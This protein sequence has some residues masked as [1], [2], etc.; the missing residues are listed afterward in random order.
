MTDWSHVGPAFDRALALS[1]EERADY[2]RELARIDQ[3]LHREVVS[4]L[5]AG[6]GPGPLDEQLSIP[7]TVSGRPPAIAGKGG[8][9]DE[10]RRLGAYELEVEIGSGGMGRVF[11]ARRADGAYEQ[12]VALKVLRWEL[13]DGSVVARFLRE[14][15]ILAR[16][17]HPAITRL[18][19]GGLADGGLPYLVMEWVEGRQLD[20]HCREA[21]L[22]LEERLVLFLDVCDAVSHAH[23]AAIIHRDLKPGNILVTSEGQVKLLDFGISK[24]AD[25]AEENLTRTGSSPLTPTW[26][27]P[28]QLNGEP[29]TTAS[30]IYSLG[31]IL[32]AL[33]VGHAPHG[34]DSPSAMEL[35][36]RREKGPPQAPSTLI[37]TSDFRARALDAVVLQALAHDPSRRYST[38]EDLARDVRNLI[39]RRPVA[40]RRTGPL[41]RFLL[42]ARRNP[43]VATVAAGALVLLAATALWVNAER[44][45]SLRQA[46]RAQR[47]GQQV[48]TL[49]NRHEVLIRDPRHEVSDELDELM[50]RLTE[51]ERE[52][53]R[54]RSTLALSLSTLA[55]GWSA[56]GEW[57][58]SRQLL[59]EARTLARD[60][61]N[62][63]DHARL[64][65][66]LGRAYAELYQQ[67]RLD[68]RGLRGRA[69]E[70]Q[71]AVARTRWAEPGLAAFARA[72]DLGRGDQ[73]TALLA[74]AAR[75]A[76][77]ERFDQAEQ[78]VYE[79]IDTHPRAVEP[80]RVL[81]ELRKDRAWR[82]HLAG[83]R[84]QA[85]VAQDQ[86]RDAFTRAI[87]VARSDPRL[88]QSLCVLETN[89][90]EVRGFN[91]AQGEEIAL[92]A[93]CS[94]AAEID[95]RSA[96]IWTAHAS[97]AMRQGIRRAQL[98]GD[99]ETALDEC[100]QF[101]R[102]ARELGSMSVMPEF[103]EATCLSV[104]SDH[105]VFDPEVTRDESLRLYERILAKEPNHLQ[106]L[107]SFAIT[108]M[109]RGRMAIEDA[110][111][112][113]LLGAELKQ[114]AQGTLPDF[115]RGERMFLRA[116]EMVPDLPL[117]WNNLGNL[118][119]H[120][121]I[122]LVRVD[123]ASAGDSFEAAQAA[124]ERARE[125]DPEYASPWIVDAQLAGG[126]AQ[127][128]EARGAFDAAA[129]Q[130]RLTAQLYDRAHVRLPALRALLE[131]AVAHRVRAL[132]FVALDPR[133]DEERGG[134]LQPPSWVQ[135]TTR[136]ASSQLDALADL[137]DVR[138]LRAELTLHRA[139]IGDAVRARKRVDVQARGLSSAPASC[140][141]LDLADELLVARVPDRR[142]ETDAGAALDRVSRLRGAASDTVGSGALL[143]LLETRLIALAEPGTDG[144]ADRR[145]QVV[146]RLVA[147]WPGMATPRGERREDR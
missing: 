26:A 67:S 86:A 17:D 33:V 31:A 122:A 113:D 99:A 140:E 102:R 20:V 90:A 94:L 97:V 53:R 98:G 120:R 81:A 76:L 52:A 3:E 32:Y 143:D 45:E 79:F 48:Q 130:H 22:S 65:R 93:S 114:I 38:V 12:T 82:F 136:R 7:T 74:D 95:P 42:W 51:M 23:R 55:E 133:F 87:E 69:L 128:E 46:A 63:E 37:S 84:E 70:A 116:I 134:T 121:G 138:C 103:F 1:D 57:E 68:L 44:T 112:A 28:E 5:E 39:E 106:T 75:L 29:L 101:A 59:E 43:V 66:R 109:D 111:E 15:Q 8:T 14:R 119:T 117:L 19:D 34:G 21:D 49:A 85:I 96:A 10:P 135:E 11:R 36:R 25:D 64:E 78:L 61:L 142:R 83:E 147:R 105:G 108:L 123:P 126:R 145:Q 80:L 125:L 137:T 71:T 89:D 13:A 35:Y 9:G 47:L 131:R 100:L 127:L 18:H 30:D 104:G 132:R 54:D 118:R 77:D 4:L 124:V 2:L 40:A 16:L 88:H 73:E 72:G 92:P 110:L 129:E 91:R 24:L 146:D 62:R 139:L 144:L 141:E 58:R 56:V 115:E 107:N 6:T 60:V 50:R 27:S 41:E